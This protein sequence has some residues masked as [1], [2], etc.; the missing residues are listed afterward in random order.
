M[1]KS[2][3]VIKWILLALLSVIVLFF[4]VRAIGQV[5]NR[6]VPDGGINE[7]GYV[8]I[9]G[10][11]QWISIYGQ[12]IE[13]PV[14][15]YLHG[16]PG[17][18][19]SSLDYAITRKFSDVFTVVTWDQR[20]CGKSWSKEQGSIALTEELMMSD[21]VELTKYLLDYLGKDRL[22][23]Y[24]HSWGT[25]YGANLALK[26]PEYYNAFIGAGQMVDLRE[27]ETAFIEAAKEW[28][29]DDPKLLEK[30]SGITE[31]DLS[32]DYFMEKNRIMEK[33]G[34]NSS[35]SEI[36]YS[37]V[38][39]VIFNPY[40]SLADWVD[41]LRWSRSMSADDSVYVKFMLDGELEK[42][43][44]TTG[45]AYQVPYYNIN[46][47]KDYQT[48]RFIAQEYFDSITAPTKKMYYLENAGHLSPLYRSEEISGI[49]HE[50][51]EEIY[52]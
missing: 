41:Y 28:A 23:L 42:F 50:I 10:V 48:N 44:L 34:Y 32:M 33:Y 9:N 18:S 52:G 16:G 12:D 13:N 5:V 7:S 47:D 27:N 46:C 26:Y 3:K 38:G 19:T 4:A 43:S 30:L 17:S 8:E 22:T 1:K 45:D 15:L 49:I 39:A 36:D 25:I 6:R 35:A 14:L 40:Y 21:A 31:D 29:A 24:G 51:A 2:G 20:N 37:P 11:K